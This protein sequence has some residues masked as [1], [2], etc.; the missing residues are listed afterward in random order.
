MGSCYV[1]FLENC[2]RK[3]NPHPHPHTPTRQ[4]R[5]FILKSNMETKTSLAGAHKGTLPLR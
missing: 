2:K 1:L 5:Y 3:K 4:L